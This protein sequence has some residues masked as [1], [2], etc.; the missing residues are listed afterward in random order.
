MNMIDLSRVS[1]MGYEVV[2]EAH[3]QEAR[4][5]HIQDASQTH[6]SDFK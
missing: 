3:N 2:V 4:M 5:D 1:K 6:H